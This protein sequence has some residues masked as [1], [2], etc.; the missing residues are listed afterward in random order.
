MKN[1][2][3]FEKM[4]GPIF[5]YILVVDILRYQCSIGGTVEMGFVIF[6]QE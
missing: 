6:G 3:R 5:K 4:N 2:T 1:C